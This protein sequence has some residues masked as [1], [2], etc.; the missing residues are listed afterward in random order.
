[1]K[2][3]AIKTTGIKLKPGD[4]FST[5][6]QTYWNSTKNLRKTDPLRIGE[7]VYIRTD[8]DCPKGQ[9]NEEIYLIKIEN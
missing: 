8:T 2:I 6:S 1:M 9:E 4:L 3:K 5:A 7:K